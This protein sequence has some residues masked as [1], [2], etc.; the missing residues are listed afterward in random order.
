M[1]SGLK[2]LNGFTISISVIDIDEGGSDGRV[3]ASKSSFE[4]IKVKL[5]VAVLVEGVK[6]AG[7]VSAHEVEG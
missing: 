6:L 5:A 2:N 4:L 7:G 1:I 3:E